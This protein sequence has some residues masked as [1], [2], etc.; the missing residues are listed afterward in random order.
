MQGAERRNSEP[1]SVYTLSM[2]VIKV[3]SLFCFS[4]KIQI[5]HFIHLSFNLWGIVQL[6]IRL[7][8][9]LIFN[10]L[11]DIIKG[12][13]KLIDKLEFDGQIHS[14]NGLLL[15]TKPTVGVLYVI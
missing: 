7:K 14:T 6:L 11:C 5:V 3:A 10:G 9:L 4:R 2:K 13:R 8:E 1:A 15:P 12:V